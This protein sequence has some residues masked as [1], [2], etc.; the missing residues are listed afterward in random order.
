MKTEDFSKLNLTQYHW[1]HFEG[2]PNVQTIRDAIE[3]VNNVTDSDIKV[4]VELEKPHVTELLTLCKMAD[5][6]FLSKEYAANLG[7]RSALEA[8]KGMKTRLKDKG[9]VVCTWGSV[10]AAY[11]SN[12][13]SNSDA[14]V[15]AIAPEKVVDTIGAGDAFIGGVIHCRSRGYSLSESVR[16]GCRVSERKITNFGFDHVA[17]LDFGSH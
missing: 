12:D 16:F 17:G 7:Y 1:I 9:E 10:G 2:R 14:L 5:L 3:K 15:D 6:V 4:S 13:G 8:V 11:A